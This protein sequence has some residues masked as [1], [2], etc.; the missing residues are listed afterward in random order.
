MRLGSCEASRQITT[1]ERMFKVFAVGLSTYA[2][3]IRL[4]E[5]DCSERW[6]CD[7]LRWQIQSFQEPGE[8]L[9]APEWLK[10][11]FDSEQVDESRLILDRLVEAL[12]A[13][14]KVFHSDRCKSL[15]QRAH[16]L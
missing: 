7:A 14:L 15:R 4:W 11:R 3:G 2:A 12:K 1:E 13:E 6:R 10:E 16:I 5:Y 8:P 9:I